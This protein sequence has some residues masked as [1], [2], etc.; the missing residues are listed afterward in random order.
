MEKISTTRDARRAIAPQIINWNRE[1]TGILYLD[2]DD[3][4]VAKK[5]TGVGGE[6]AVSQMTYDIC[7]N[8]AHYE[9]LSDS[10]THSIIQWHTH[11]GFAPVE[12]SD[13]DME[14]ALNLYSGMRQY[15][16][17]V[18]DF[19]ITNQGGDT[20]SYKAHGLMKQIQFVSDMH[21]ERARGNVDK[22]NGG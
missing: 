10:P 16:W 21:L 18:K 2:K 20:F 22:K 3:N 15:G 17:R 6:N 14:S 5:L 19:I 8:I 11:P 12:P 7:N 1:H 9:T 4:L 13:A